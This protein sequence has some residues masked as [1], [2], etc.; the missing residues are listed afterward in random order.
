MSDKDTAKQIRDLEDS[1]CN[2]RKIKE[3]TE[4]RDDLKQKGYSDSDIDK[5]AD[6]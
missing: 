1:L 5:L 3:A 6:E 2:R 4:L